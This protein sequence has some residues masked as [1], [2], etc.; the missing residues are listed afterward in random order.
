MSVTPQIATA[1]VLAARR[2]RFSAFLLDSLLFALLFAPVHLLSSGEE[3]TDGPTFEAIVQ[4]Y[5]GNPDWWI[6][7]ASTALFAAYFCVQHALWG[8]TLGK[9]L[10]R[11]KVVSRATG[12]PPGLGRSAIRALVHP[13]L[14]GLPYVGPP[15]FFVN[16]LAI[17]VHPK[18]RCLH[19][20]ITGTMVIDLSGPARRAGGGLLF[21]LG[22]LVSLLAAL[23]LVD[24][25]LL[26]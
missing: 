25:L 23:A 16:A 9:R 24:A 5:A 3:R 13:A 14:F 10:C 26:T 19:D 18:R 2:H 6:E 15:L 12:L 11:L 17:M 20:M 1:P 21:G 22:L 4:P 7:V 8:Q